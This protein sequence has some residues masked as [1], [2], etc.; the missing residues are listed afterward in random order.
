MYRRVYFCWADNGTLELELAPGQ[1]ATLSKATLER[2]HVLLE[3]LDAANG[4]HGSL[5]HFPEGYAEAWLEMLK[6]EERMQAFPLARILLY[7]Q[8]HPVFQSF[9][10][11]LRCIHKQ[12]V[13]D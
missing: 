4:D 7:A 9:T 12:L 8:V 5:L 13:A 10:K 2:S 1:R 11:L 6:D 3:M